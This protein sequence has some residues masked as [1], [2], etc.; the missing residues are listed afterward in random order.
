MQTLRFITVC[1]ALA[2]ALA[3]CE[4]S[5]K[6]PKAGQ[7]TDQAADTSKVGGGGAQE[8]AQPE[9]EGGTPGEQAAA[10]GAEAAADEVRPPTAE[11][12]AE[13][14]K[15]LEGKGPLMATIATTMGELHCELFADKAP[16]TVANFV[17]LARGLKAWR[18]PETDEVHA[19]PLYDGVI[20]HRVIPN[21]M[22]QTGDPLGM[23]TG[24]PGYNFSDEIHPEL[25]HTKGGT[26][27]MANAGPGTNGSQFFITE[28][29]TPWLDGRHTVFGQ[30]AEAELV[31]KMTNVPRDGRD[32]PQEEIKIERVTISRGR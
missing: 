17:G 1:A 9:S 31:A 15:D 24:G 2:L 6:D 11:D 8:G 5:S 3:G 10:G 7:A 19:K 4:R 27:S 14:T 12:L 21:F 26:L 16:M 22:V 18:H 13:Y 25:R 30:C 32:R 23:G 28:K 29:A 20:F